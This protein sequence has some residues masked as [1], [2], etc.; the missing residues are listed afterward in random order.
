MYL[1]CSEIGGG[2]CEE[3]LSARLAVVTALLVVG[4]PTALA[5]NHGNRGNHEKHGKDGHQRR[6]TCSGGTATSPQ[7]ITA[8]SYGSVTVTGVCRFNGDITINGDLTIGDGAS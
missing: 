2:S 4:G 3:T 7:D 6:L 5:D 8:G 1:H